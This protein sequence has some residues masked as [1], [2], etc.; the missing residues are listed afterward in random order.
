VSS[1]G[2]I[3]VTGATGA[4]GGRVAA[5]LADRGAALRLV[6]RDPA[7]A[8]S[9]DGAQVARASYQDGPAMRAA[10]TGVDT[11]FLVSASEAADRVAQHRSAVDAAAAAGV[12]RVVYLS[13][14]AA[15]PG[16]TF[17]FARDHFATEE[18]V[19][20]S[21]LAWTFLRP[22]MYL[23]FMPLLVGPDGAIRGPAGEG[24]LAG[25]ARDDLADVAAAVLTAGG[26][27]DG[28]TYD[29][30]GPQALTLAEVAAELARA[31]RRPI[32]YVPETLEQAR[33]S[34]APSGAPAWTI[35]GWV[36]TYAAIAT[37]EM[38]VVSDTVAR[39]AGHQP[40]TLAAWLRE[41]G[42]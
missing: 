23:D 27:H 3:A 34:R 31:S 8:P 21:G 39:V 6:V 18:H 19:R 25:V 35:E 12:R 5:R 10:L 37:G 22:S 17:T 4:L 2:L 1:A 36:T 38:D 30:T 14:L 7:R 32:A 20:A 42:A 16:A 41:H 40:A 24:R 33:A 15:A 9:L 28:R 26:E 29:V 11:L 13:F